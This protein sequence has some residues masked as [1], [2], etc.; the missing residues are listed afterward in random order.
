MR[1]RPPVRS[2]TTAELSQIC[3]VMLGCA[4]MPAPGRPPACSRTTAE[5]S[6]ICLV[7][8]GCADM[9]AP[10]QPQ[11][12]SQT[13]AKLSQI[14]LVMLGCADMP[15]PGQP[16]ARSPRARARPP[17]TTDPPNPKKNT[18]HISRNTSQLRTHKINLLGKSHCNRLRFQ[19]FRQSVVK[20]KH[21]QIV[22]KNC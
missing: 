14:C 11:V 4:H 21:Q 2:R 12:R 15:A 18:L 6:Q 1:A 17:R 16:P 13:T 20:A 10:G 19:G 9:P 8:L 5:L 7:M 3:L 22:N